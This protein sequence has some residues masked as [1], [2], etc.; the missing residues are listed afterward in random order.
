MGGR[1]ILAALVGGALMFAGGFVEHGILGWVGRQI[2]RPAEDSSVNDDFKQ[3]F[4]SRERYSIPPVGPGMQNLSKEHDGAL[5]Q[6]EESRPSGFGVVA[7]SELGRMGSM[8]LGRQ[9]AT[10]FACARLASVFG[11]FA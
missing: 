2:H 1:I 6:D 8:Q 9:F 5:N 10:F 4:A 7:R 11:G 3:H